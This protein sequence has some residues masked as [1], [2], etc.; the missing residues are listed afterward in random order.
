MNS[1]DVISHHHCMF[2]CKII[3]DFIIKIYL[4][5]FSTGRLQSQFILGA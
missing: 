5:D 3:M 1:S 4:L 2:V